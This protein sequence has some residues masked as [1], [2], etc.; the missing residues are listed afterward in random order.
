M[1]QNYS[2]SFFIFQCFTLHV[3]HQ[4]VINKKPDQ[5]LWNSSFRSERKIWLE[6]D[7][8]V[9]LSNQ[10]GEL[11]SFCLYLNIVSK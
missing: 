3:T 10:K 11:L 5:T 6:V 8:S 9:F 2:T 7:R 4:F 1:V